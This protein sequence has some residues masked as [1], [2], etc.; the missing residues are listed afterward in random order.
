[1]GAG[2][3]FVGRLVILS[4]QEDRWEA[5][6]SQNLPT[7][8]SGAAWWAESCGEGHSSVQMRRTRCDQRHG[9]TNLARE[10][11]ATIFWKGRGTAQKKGGNDDPEP[12]RSHLPYPD[13]RHRHFYHQLERL[14]PEKGRWGKS[15]WLGQL[16]PPPCRVA[17]SR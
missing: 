13:H 14:L 7:L 12:K 15:T 1:M 6:S 5:V 3:E 4:L 17:D 11:E 9:T 16:S 2:L 8:P 10:M